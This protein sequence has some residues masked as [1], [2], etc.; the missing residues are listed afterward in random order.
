M[1]KYIHFNH[2]VLEVKQADDHQETG[3]WVLE[4][5]DKDKENTTTEVFDAVMVCTGHHADKRLPTFEGEICVNY[6]H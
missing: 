4:V 3:Q 5:R 1:D 6:N 2:E